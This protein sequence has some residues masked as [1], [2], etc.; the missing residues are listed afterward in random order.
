MQDDFD[1]VTLTSENV[2]DYVDHT[3]LNLVVGRI[4]SGR[5]TVS[6]IL[7]LLTAEALFDQGI[8]L[9]GQEGVN[10]IP[11][12]V[13]VDDEQIPTG[14]DRAWRGF[15][16]MGLKNWPTVFEQNAH[17]SYTPASSCLTLKTPFSYVVHAVSAVFEPTLLNAMGF[18]NSQAIPAPM[19]LADHRIRVLNDPLLLKPNVFFCSMERVVGNFGPNEF[20]TEHEGYGCLLA[21]FIA[22]NGRPTV[23]G[24]GMRQ[25]DDKILLLPLPADAVRQAIDRQNSE[26]TGRLC[27]RVIDTVAAFKEV[28][29]VQA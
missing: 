12:P 20:A 18:Y 27:N 17:H 16:H 9:G 11:R 7:A 23:F 29:G 19:F 25:L 28:M 2:L 6:Q 26:F 22:K 13:F 10:C 14:L 3:Q 24:Y 4:H 1:I 15:V 21:T 5:S 8:T